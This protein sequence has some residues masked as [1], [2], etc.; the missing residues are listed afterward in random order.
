ME[1]PEVPIDE[2]REHI[3]HHAHH[4]KDTFISSVA[5]STAVIA[6]FAAICS[7]LAG[8]HANEAMLS[9]LQSSDQ[10]AFFQARSI[11]AQVVGSKIGVFQAMGKEPLAKDVQEQEKYKSGQE[12]IKKKAE[13]LGEESEEHLARHKM[14]AT[15]VTMLQ[16]AIAIGAI[17]ALTRRRSIWVVSLIFGLVGIGFL[18]FEQLLFV[19]HATPHG[20]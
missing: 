17:S 3:D 15:G 5:V 7:L 1:Q 16:I 8:H 10:W 4:E 12:E 14:L 6:A 11:K 18:V 13:T 20:G 19:F 2:I 9:Q